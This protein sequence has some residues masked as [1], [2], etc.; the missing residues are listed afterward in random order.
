MALFPLALTY[1]QGI[2]YMYYTD[3]TGV[4]RSVTIELYQL[5][6]STAVADT[7]RFG[8]SQ[9]TAA[10]VNGLNHV[11]YQSEVDIYGTFT[12]IVVYV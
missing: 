10:T 3:V 6:P 5:G 7:P 9:I 2:T 8:H 12:H 4:L 11:F 1:Y